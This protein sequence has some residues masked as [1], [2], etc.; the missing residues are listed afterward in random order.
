MSNIKSDNMEKQTEIDVIK[1]QKDE[2]V[3][4]IS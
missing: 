1:K 4:Q 2:K 3:K